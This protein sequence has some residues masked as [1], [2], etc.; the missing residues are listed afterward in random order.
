MLHLD[1]ILNSCSRAYAIFAE[2]RPDLDLGVSSQTI[3]FEG[4]VSLVLTLLNIALII[5]TAIFMF[6]VKSVVRYDG[7]GGNWQDDVSKYTAAKQVV[8]KD[9]HGGHLGALA[10]RYAT[11]FQHKSHAVRA[12]CCS[13]C[14]V[15]AQSRSDAKPQANPVAKGDA[16]SHDISIDHVVARPEAVSIFAPMAE[17]DVKKVSPVSDAEAVRI[18]KLAAEGHKTISRTASSYRALSTAGKDAGR[19]YATM[20]GGT[21]TP[22]SLLSASR[23]VANVQKDAHL[24]FWNTL[25]HGTLKNLTH[26]RQLTHSQY[27]EFVEV[28]QQLNLGMRTEK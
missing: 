23:N 21:R 2:L 24:N 6:W 19:K 15:D 28:H 17:G 12:A 10:K 1:I 27:R 26:R 4:L 8:R 25:Q 7:T 18:A 22:K 13:C 3:A 14:G 11:H 20:R 16:P 5:V 9:T